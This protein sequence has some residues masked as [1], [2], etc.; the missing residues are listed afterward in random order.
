M[1]Y[2]TANCFCHEAKFVVR[3]KAAKLLFLYNP[4]LFSLFYI[5]YFQLFLFYLKT[6]ININ[7][8]HVC[9]WFFPH[10]SLLRV[11]VSVFIVQLIQ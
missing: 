4:A 1:E 9:Y 2:I 8:I 10:Y 3:I 7:S 11:V 5:F 6:N